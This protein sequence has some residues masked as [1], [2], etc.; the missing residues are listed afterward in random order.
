MCGLCGMIG[1]AG[2]PVDEMVLRR[3]NDVLV[4]RGPDDE[5]YFTHDN[6]GL[7]FRRLSIIDI[8]G[9]HQPLCNEDQTVWLVFNGEIYN[10]GPL[11]EALRQRGH[12]YAT[13]SDGEVIVHLYEERGIE[14]VRELR[15]MFAFALYDVRSREL[16]LARDPFGIKPLYYADLPQQFLFASEVKSLLASHRIEPKVHAQSLWNYFTFQYVPDPD[17]MWEGIRKVPPAHYLRWKDGQVSL[18]RYWRAEFHPDESR[19]LSYFVEGIREKLRESVKLHTQADVPV[20]A[21]LSSGVDSSAIVAWMR[22]FRPVHTFTVGFDGA[23]S[24]TDE[25]ELA[26]FT[27]RYLDT[28][29]HEVR[30]SARQYQDELPKLVYYQDDPVAD[31]SAIGLYFVS[32]LAGKYVTVILSGEGSDEIFGGYPIYHEPK[33]LRFFS[34]IPKRLRERLRDVAAW[35]PPGIKGQSFLERGS[36]PLERRFVGNAFIF[37]EEAKRE[38]LR[39]IDE[40]QITCKPFDITGVYYGET[41]H[42]DDITRMQYVDLHTWL[43]GDILMKADKMTMAN[44]V[45]LRVPFLDKEVFEFAATIPTKYR[46]ARGTTKY[47]L[48]RAVAD[49]LPPS[50]YT[51]AKLGFPIPIR[52]WIRGEMRDFVHDVLSSDQ[53][54]EYLDRKYTLRL[55]E[56]HCAGKRDFA[57]P[58]WTILIFLLWHQIQIRNSRHFVPSEP[59]TA[60]IRRVQLTGSMSRG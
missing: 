18:H 14:C 41:A 33:S 27:A 54:D 5:G 21:L 1:K 49:I 53:A 58:I 24:G 34:Y 26:R 43:P 56:E 60:G 52:E 9:G 45:E 35:L 13:H 28:E 51:R 44:S 23:S 36:L 37:K 8:Q 31:P 59:P 16:F 25:L 48:R 10:Y 19:P 12:R 57:R 11:R 47:V 55:L 2:Q 42:L 46:I 38:L 39:G 30:I 15:G 50:V 32:E 20:G 29:H 22:E 40:S 3:M 4:H 17:T 6:V 7:G